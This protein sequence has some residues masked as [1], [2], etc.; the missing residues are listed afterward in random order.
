MESSK[1]VFGE[2]MGLFISNLYNFFQF[3]DFAVKRAFVELVKNYILKFEKELLISLGSFVL[4]IV[5][6]L[7][8]NNSDMVFSIHEILYRAEEIVGT[9]KFYG[10]IWKT[11]LRSPRC[12]LTAIK[13]L[14]LKIP[15]NIDEA[16]TLNK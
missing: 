12:R 13:F 1:A 11:M 8:D 5:P 14:D 9:A 16:A 10:E 4:A 7:D 6:A 15:R 3:A 2:D